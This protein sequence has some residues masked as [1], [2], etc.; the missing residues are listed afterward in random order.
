M[1]LLLEEAGKLKIYYGDESGFS[2]DPCISYGWQPPGEYVGITPAGGRRI[3]AFGLM[4]R[5]NDLHAY[6]FEKS[7]NSEVVAA[8]ID[9]FAKTVAMKTVIVLDNASIH[10]S[11]EF[12]LK[13]GEW[14]EKG[15]RIF[16][17][18]PYSPHLNLIE[19]LWRK[20]KY[21]WL[22]PSDYDSM[23]TLRDAVEN[24]LAS[25]GKELKIE[26]GELRHFTEHKAKKAANIYG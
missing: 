10:C 23:D 12:N 1:Y 16:Y 20:M 13:L 2:L 3:N 9:E 21:D 14:R 17:L 4:S 6:T 24:I 5:D 26:F 15:I 25:V 18:P 8:C 7:V 19:T 11:K 22:K